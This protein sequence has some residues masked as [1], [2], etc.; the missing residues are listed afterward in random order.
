MVKA[1]K[2]KNQLSFKRAERADD[3]GSASAGSE[4][5]EIS[6][7]GIIISAELDE[8]FNAVSIMISTDKEEEFLIAS[9]D[10]GNDL[11]NHIRDTVRI[12]GMIWQDSDGKKIIKVR[13]YEILDHL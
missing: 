9:D 3:M 4:S 8:D 1:K 2:R 13:D 5:M 10:R 7:K 11:F 12:T 6:L